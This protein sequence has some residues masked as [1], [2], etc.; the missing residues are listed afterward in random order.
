LGRKTHPTKNFSEQSFMGLSSGSQAPAWE[1]VLGQSFA[2]LKGQ[3]CR[4]DFPV[5]RPSLA[6]KCVPKHELG[7]E[8]KKLVL[9][10]GTAF[11]G[12]A[13]LTCFLGTGWKAC[14]TNLKNFKTGFQ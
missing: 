7:D 10:G 6:A 2:L 8:N 13:R 11:P 4:R 12:C 5:A 9:A 1:P 3:K 14:A